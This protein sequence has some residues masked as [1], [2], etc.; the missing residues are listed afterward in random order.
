M[1]TLI[2]TTLLS[3]GVF[4]TNAFATESMT[5]IEKQFNTDLGVQTIQGAVTKAAGTTG[6]AVNKSNPG[7]IEL[8]KIYETEVESYYAED[9][10]EMMQHEVS[11]S[12]AVS[13]KGFTIDL[14]QSNDSIALQEISND[15]QKFEEAIY[16]KLLPQLL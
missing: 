2:M 11:V 3:S 7:Q 10:N 14:T 15:L 6:W 16:A 4:L 5:K 13:Q 1:K 8:T 12:V 9:V